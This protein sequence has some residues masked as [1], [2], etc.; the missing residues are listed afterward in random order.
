MI[1]S[2]I[3]TEEQVNKMLRT[4]NAIYGLDDVFGEL[5][6]APKYKFD[7]NRYKRNNDLRTHDYMEYLKSAHQ[8]VVDTSDMSQL[9]D[10]H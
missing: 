5:Q 3:Y 1:K 2:K 10:R 7:P 6:R 4:S 8:A 9:G